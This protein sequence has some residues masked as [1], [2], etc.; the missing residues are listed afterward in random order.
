MKTIITYFWV[1]VLIVLSIAAN[2]QN[3]DINFQNTLT[4]KES[5]AY[6]PVPSLEIWQKIAAAEENEPVQKGIKASY[7]AI[8]HKLIISGTTTN[9]DVEVWDV[10]G[11]TVFE[12]SSADPNTVFN[13]NSLPAGSYY[14]NYSNGN[15]SQGVKLIIR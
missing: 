2:A 11:N 6:E 10:K 9:G 7:N 8:E 14:I 12:K 13:A 1:I 5:L 4:G 3:S 15:F